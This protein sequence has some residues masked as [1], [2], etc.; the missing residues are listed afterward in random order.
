MR[1]LAA[2]LLCGALANSVAAVTV[3]EAAPETQAAALSDGATLSLA[4]FR[5][6]VVLLDFWASWCAPCLKSLPAYSELRD[7]LPRADFEVLAISVDE[8]A[9]DAQRFVAAHALSFPVA[10]AN[11][12]L[13]GRWGVETMPSAY[14]IDREGIVRAVHHGYQSADLDTLRQQIL[15]L[16]EQAS[17]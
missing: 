7:A 4:A 2:L 8:S 10:W 15:D 11:P 13:P 14:L 6:K 12:E 3:G 9:A 1:A 16:T 5:G 17:P